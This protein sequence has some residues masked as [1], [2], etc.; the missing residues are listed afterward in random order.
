[1]DKDEK[2]KLLYVWDFTCGECFS[3]KDEIISLLKEFCKKW[4]FQLEKGEG[5]NGYIHFQGRLSLKEKRRRKQVKEKFPKGF[6]FTPTSNENKRNMFYV[7]KEHTRIDGPWSDKDKVIYIPRQYRGML[8]TMKPF[9]QVI[10]DSYDIFEPR[11][12]NIIINE[13]GNVG[14]TV[15]AS[16]CELHGRGID[17]PP[18][19][20]GEKLI[21]ST[22]DILMATENRAPGIVFIDIPRAMKQDKLR[23]IFTAIEQI[24]KGKVYDQR[25]NYK[26]WWFDSPQIWVFVNEPPKTKWLSHDRWN[27]WEIENDELIKYIED[28][29]ARKIM[30]HIHFE[31]KG[32]SRRKL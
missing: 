15:I 20:D 6:Y 8:E 32:I 2:N 21:Q 23:G 30:K 25:Y 17:L 7:M 13:S 31:K 16:L 11:K 3:N 26:M 12:I 10:W 28:E 27:K 19:N 9:Q 5:E 1:M 18:I 29:N 24:K 4:C 22:C 14:K